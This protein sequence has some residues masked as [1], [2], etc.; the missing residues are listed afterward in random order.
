MRACVI[1][2][3][4]SYQACDWWISGQLTAS[5]ELLSV[6]LCQVDLNQESYF[7]L[8]NKSMFLL[9]SKLVTNNEREM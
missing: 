1:A 3:S 8:N 7:H 5:R 2:T 9:P 4:S 6:C